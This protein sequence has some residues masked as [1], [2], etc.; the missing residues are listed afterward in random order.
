MLA[1]HPPDDLHA[2]HLLALAR[3]AFHVG[4]LP[5]AGFLASTAL[6]RTPERATLLRADL[7]EIQQRSAAG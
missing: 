4:D 1:Q 3:I 5:R 7:L 6:G 2:H